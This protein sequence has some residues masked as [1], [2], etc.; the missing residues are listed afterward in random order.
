MSVSTNGIALSER[1]R[2]ARGRQSQLGGVLQIGKGLC[3]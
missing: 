2:G 1:R 3:G